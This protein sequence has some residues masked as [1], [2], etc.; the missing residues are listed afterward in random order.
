MNRVVDQAIRNELLNPLESYIVQ[1]PAG[2]GKTE[3]LTQRI[4]ALLAVVEKPENILA[5]TFTRKAA[6]EMQ[7]RVVS[8]LLLAQRNEPDAPHEKYRWRLARKVLERDQEKGWHLVDNASRLNMTTI[9]S[10]SASLSGALPLLSQTGALPKIA[11]NA[12]QYYLQA[13]ENMLASVGDKDEVSD[14]ILS[15]LKHKDNNLA[16]VTD[17]L[18][19]MLAKRLQWM[20]TI[21]S[22]AAKFEESQLIESLRL[23]IEE[24]LQL[25]YQAIPTDITSELPAL[26]NQASEVLKRNDKVNKPYLQTLEEVEALAPPN[27]DDLAVWKA[28]AELFLKAGKKAE[29]LTSFNA[30]S[31][32][33]TEKDAVNDEQKLLFKHNKKLVKQIASEL[34]ET[35]GA[36]QLLNQI[37]LLPDA[38]EQSVSQQALKAAVALLPLA[39]AHLKLVF[40]RY[41]IIDFSEL[42][43]AS[44]EALGHAEMPSDLALAMDYKLEHILIDEFQDTSTPQ[45][46][47]IKLLTAGWDDSS[48]RTLFL[49]GD[50][51]QSIYRFRDA[52]V[53]LFMQIREQGIG[54]IRPK[55]RQLQ[56]NFRS[57]KVI[58]DW[59][60]QQFSRIMPA[61]EDL[62]FSAVSYAH[63][64]AFNDTN[65]GALVQS[66]LT[67]DAEDNQAQ[68]NKVVEIVERHLADNKAGGVNR[69]LAI[70]ARSRANLSEI[71]QLLNQHN[72]D[73]Q[74]VEIDRLSQKMVVRD[75]LNLAYALC[76]AYD[77]VSWVAC[78][79]GPWF[80][81]SLNDIRKV[82]VNT[83]EQLP[84]PERLA[85]TLAHMSPES[86]ERCEKLLPLLQSTIEQK[87][88]KPF[89]KWLLGCF[90][91]VGAMAQ[92]DFESD[93]DDLFVC[94]DKLSE[95]QE[96]GELSDRQIVSDAIDQLFATPNPKADGQV[97]VMTIHKSKGLEF[98]TVILP[99]LDSGSRSGEQALL[100]W[101]EVLDR[102]G[103]PH[104]LLAISKQT[105]QDSDSVYQYI[106]YLE[107]EKGKYEDQRV[108]YVAATRSKKNLHL[109][110]N[111]KSD[112]KS[113]SFK[114]PL[115]SSFLAM[116]WPGINDSFQ[117]IENQKAK[118]DI[119]NENSDLYLS[120]SVKQVKL[121]N[122]LEYPAADL[123]A[124]TIDVEFLASQQTVSEQAVSDQV[125]S[126]V[127]ESSSVIGTVL[128]R[129]LQWISERYQ[130]GF[131]L[132]D[133]WR[134]ITR[135]QLSADYQFAN[136]TSLD[137]AV[138]K[139]IVGI[140]N[141]LEDDFGQMV[142]AARESAQSELEM[143]KK[144]DTGSF[145]TRVIDR[146]FVKE[147]VRWIIDYKSSQP[148]KDESR[149]D[150]F[151][152]EKA[153]YMAQLSD[154]FKMFAKIEKRKIIAGLYFPLLAHFEVLIEN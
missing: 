126:A 48:Q 71:I 64:T 133:N 68:A 77:E 142:L 125:Q 132:P 94:L 139:V 11:E 143:H 7:G 63:S 23:V 55:F 49:V 104:N 82:L 98:D 140:T 84:M 42:A 99:R 152:R 81:L 75:L 73:Y 44:L 38:I 97:Q 151:A 19:Q 118:L 62:T 59:V 66:W 96:G 56:V 114:L 89:R 130:P 121:A 117:V 134:E 119:D 86:A 111:I 27:F 85:K 95:L 60:N 65:E 16:Q 154:Y 110:A 87:G 106:A 37:R 31:G 109:L 43:L 102:Y 128:H 138:D 149:S 107:S 2:S 14:N 146:T 32:F 28:I 145:L 5:I 123:A 88:R 24:K 131:N 58:V 30:R 135:S 67:V 69:S 101:T 115:A 57:N 40:S 22:H 53:S 78:M 153:Q 52:N 93:R 39:V 103:E 34:G 15:L 122:A 144:I 79:R 113:D 150:F 12:Q 17:L 76:D 80:G 129:Q 92:L 147:D 83:E 45:I 9:D 137:A 127:A 51:M 120:R 20:A 26:L 6:A 148:L 124:S 141:T 105:G 50:P 3:L 61:T 4:L 54:H 29:L 21:S 46:E 18:S 100:K 108:L 1:A 41:N 90:V 136:D 35:E 13:A 25:V 112:P 36:T 8:A 72:I 116:L 70:L 10:L 91:A 74:A 47:L 33:P